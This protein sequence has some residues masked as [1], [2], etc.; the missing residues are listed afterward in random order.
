MIFF[1]FFFLIFV[2][3][4][5]QTLL[6]INK[7]SLERFLKEGVSTN[8]MLCVCVF[9]FV[10]VFLFVY[11]CTFIFVCVRFSVSFFFFYTQINI[12]SPPISPYPAPAL[13]CTCLT[14]MPSTPH[15]CNHPLIYPDIKKISSIHP[16][17]YLSIHPLIILIHPSIHPPTS[18]YP[19]AR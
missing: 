17:I 18:F 15:S 3:N 6:E 1:L 12:F 5:L 2:I 11:A 10:C 8:H 14:N 4:E 16:L 19:S 13:P 7:S 9:V